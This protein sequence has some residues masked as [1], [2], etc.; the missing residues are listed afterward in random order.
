MANKPYVWQMVK[1]AAEKSQNGIITYREIRDYIAAHYENVREGTITAQ[2]ISC[3]VNNP[4][5]VHYPE[6]SKPRVS[7]GKNDFLYYVER[8][9][10]TLY[11]SAKHGVWG[12]TES[13]GGKPLVAFL[14]GDDISA[15][16]HTPPAK[17]DGP[18]LR[19]QRKKLQKPDVPR[20]AESQLLY[21]LN[22]WDDLENYRLQESALD[23]LFF[24][25][26]PENTDIDDVLIKAS[27]LNDF[28]ST[29]IFSIFTVAK[30]IVS[31]DIDE[32]IIGGDEHLVDEIAKVKMENGTTKN[33][34]S[35]ATKYCSHHK[36][37]DYPI[38]DSYVDKVLK[39]FRDTDGFYSFS[40]DDLKNYGAFKS[41]LL[42]FQEFY[43][44]T[45][46][47]LKD[48]DKYIW[49]LGKDKFPNSYKSRSSNKR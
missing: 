35:F 43:C 14:S 47:T 9:K 30:H 4:N 37:L 46:Y 48:I 24:E 39:Y 40:N 18:I 16:A 34:Y 25:T 36:P 3:S 49:Q 44:L 29:N 27:S 11:D 31:L 15:F 21:Y 17:S 20:P 42:H 41:I 10:V 26:Y 38:Y 19:Q 12:I 2:T 22:A 5:R 13:E 8:G 33:F 32:R 6:N 23:K 1:E 7:N 28:Y 45:A